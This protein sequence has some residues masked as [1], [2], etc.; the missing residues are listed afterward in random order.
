MSDFVTGLLHFTY[1]YPLFMAYMW[2]FGA[3]Y[4]YFYRERVETHAIDD[5][6]GHS[7]P[8]P[9]SFIV[10]CHDEGQN[11]E[12]T[13]KSLLNQ[14]YSEFEII[15]INDAS[16][17]NTGSILDRLALQYEHVRVIHFKSNQGKAMALRVG[18]VASRHNF[19]V[20]IDGD[21]WLDPHATSWI[22]Q[23]FPDGPRVGAVTGNPRVR[24]RTSLLG[25]IQV[26]EFSSIIGVIK[27]AQRIYGRVFTVSGV[28]AA[29]RKS[30][31]HQIGYWD[32]H[33]VTEDI[34]ISWRLQLNHWDIRYEPNALC[35]ILMPESLRGLW[36]QRL[37]WAQGAIEVLGRNFH[38]LLTW[39]RRRM[40]IVG[41][42]LI[43]S[44]LWAYTIGFVFLLWAVGHVVD[45]PPALHTSTIVPG[46]AGAVLA[47]TCLMQFAVS[48]VIDSRYES[49]L[50]RYYYWMIWY[51]MVYWMIQSAAAI[52]AVPRALLRRRK[53]RAIWVSPDRGIRPPT[54]G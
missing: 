18:A 44:T 6:P 32:L 37:R 1:Y 28:V 41:L 50:G 33:T 2:M 31:L 49:G 30:A 52:V 36:R 8:P 25:K 43:V 42:E 40:W 17:D 5:P 29:F 15:A 3:L 20:C 13:I 23:H 19:L 16:T 53:Q 34:D 46:W 22:M 9:V 21:A 35:W 51:P 4:Y 10:P 54:V 24:N 47:F 38:S 11:V 48:L 12:E 27:R 14:K 7:D 39:R 45:L 26:G